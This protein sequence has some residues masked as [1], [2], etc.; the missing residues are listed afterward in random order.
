MKN[1]FVAFLFGLII[2]AGA[3]WY[4]TEGQ[5]KESVQRAQ[6]KVASGAERMKDAISEKVSDLNL[7]S[8][9]IKEELA[10]TG[11][12]V[13]K[14]AQEVGAKVADVTANAR[15]TAAIKAKLAETGYL[16]GGSSPEELETLLKSEI[17][18]WSAVIKSVGIKI[19]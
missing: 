2:G 3:F 16:A 14:K 9:D 4:F 13:R 11:K 1:S 17:A 18:K 7:R 19:D 5:K 6:E 10:R 12:V 15:T 8:D